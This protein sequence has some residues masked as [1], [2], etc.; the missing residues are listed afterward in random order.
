MPDRPKVFVGMPR[1]G[2]VHPGAAQHLFRAQS[3]HINVAY[4]AHG[5]NSLTPNAFNDLLLAALNLRDEGKVTHFAMIHAD[6]EPS[7]FHWLDVLFTESVF[8]HVPVIAAVVPIK[9]DVPDPPTS[10]AIGYRDDPWKLVRRIHVSERSTLPPTFTRHSIGLPD[11]QLLLINTGLWLANLTH[12]AWDY[13]P[14]FGIVTRITR[15]SE[16]RRVAQCRS[17]DLEMSRFLDRHKVPYAATWKV[18]VKHWGDKA[19]TN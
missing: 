19:W 1:Y 18:G 9:N 11:D 6:V 10:T 5:Q 7:T 14:G 17:E 8:H 3:S 16:G 2:T 4:T 15:D 12:P 13:F